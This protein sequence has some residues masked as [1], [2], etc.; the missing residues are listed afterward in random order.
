M[1]FWDAVEHL[2]QPD[3]RKVQPAGALTFT[4][5]TDRVYAGAPQSLAM[6]FPGGGLEIAQSASLPD[7]VV[8]NPGAERCAALDDMPADGYTG[9]LCV[10]AALI[11]QPVELA[12]GQAW[13]G[14][15]SLR[16]TDPA[17]A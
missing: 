2:Q 16:V 10:E 1:T 12:P 14:W 7:T 13:S 11:N 15:Q 4:G 3:L 9:M 8:W 17:A 6:G 5:E